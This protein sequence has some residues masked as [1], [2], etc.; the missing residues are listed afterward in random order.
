[1]L[2]AQVKLSLDA[3]AVTAMVV[4]QRWDDDQREAGL[5]LVDDM[6]ADIVVVRHPQKP[7]GQVVAGR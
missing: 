1:M 4:H 6:E 2:C 3:A 5:E 7:S